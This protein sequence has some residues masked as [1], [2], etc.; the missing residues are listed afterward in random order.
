MLGEG[1]VNRG[2]GEQAQREQVEKRD[3][4]KSENTFFA[5]CDKQGYYG[6]IRSSIPKDLMTGTIM[7]KERE[8][9]I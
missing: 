9:L 4:G 2:V 6:G 8:C 1:E 3:R 7:L 5:F